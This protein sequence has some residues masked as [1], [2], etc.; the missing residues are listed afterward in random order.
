MRAVI[1][2]VRAP[3]VNGCRWCGHLER[4]HGLTYTSGAGYHLWV[5]PTDGQRKARFLARQNWR[6]AP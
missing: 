2:H 1:R 4:G 5:P 3:E 6:A